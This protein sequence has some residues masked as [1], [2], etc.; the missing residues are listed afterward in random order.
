LDPENKFIHQD[1]SMHFQVDFTILSA[2]LS[3]LKNDMR[4]A[5][6]PE[7]IY[8]MV[9]CNIFPQIFWKKLLRSQDA[10]GYR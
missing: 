9:L 8:M 3:H 10:I 6:S 7:G 5:K 4:I 2:T 1:G